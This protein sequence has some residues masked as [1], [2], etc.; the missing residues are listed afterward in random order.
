MISGLKKRRIFNPDNIGI[1]IKTN[2]GKPKANSPPKPIADSNNFRIF[3]TGNKSIPAQMTKQD[4]KISD[5]SKHLFWDVD[6]SVID[7]VKHDKYIIN[8]VLQFGLYKDWRTILKFYG[9]NKIKDI[10][11]N[12]RDLD[13]KSLEFISVLT[14]IPKEEFR[15]Y[16][17][18]QLLPKHWD[19]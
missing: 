4:I 10:T 16:T 6:P 12:M 14:K 13:D 7:F 9:I 19:F 15:C 11:L 3:V 17:M 2:K 1:Y 18:K 8:Q 5:F